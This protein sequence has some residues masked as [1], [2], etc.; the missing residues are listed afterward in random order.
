M[1]KKNIANSENQ[2][3]YQ[4]DAFDEFCFSKVAGLLYTD[5]NSIIK[6]HSLIL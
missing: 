2:E 4:K 5:L 3:N 1:F 6:G